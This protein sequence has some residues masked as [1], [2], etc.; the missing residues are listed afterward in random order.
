MVVLLDP[1][2]FLVLGALVSELMAAHQLQSNNRSNV[3]YNVA[4]DTRYFLAHHLVE[5]VHVEV[6]VVAVHLLQDGKT[7]RRFRCPFCSR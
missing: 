4:R 3:L 5:G 2:A 7:L 1:M 6:A